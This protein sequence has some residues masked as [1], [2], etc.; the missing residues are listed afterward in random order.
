MKHHFRIVSTVTILIGLIYGCTTSLQTDSGQGGGASETIALTI[1]GDSITGSVRLY[2]DN[3]DSALSNVSI[4]LYEDD[5][6]TY[7]NNLALNFIDSTTTNN[8]GAFTFSNL[9]PGGYN[10]LAKNKV[11]IKDAFLSEIVING[12]TISLIDTLRKT[13]DLSG[14]VWL[15]R[16]NSNSTFD[17]IVAPFYDVYI[18]GSPYANI[19]NANGVFTLLNLAVGTFPVMSMRAR[20]VLDTS[21]WNGSL[22]NAIIIIN[23]AYKNDVTIK[24]ELSLKAVN[25]FTRH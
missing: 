5:Y 10:I 22:E 1:S 13:G 7:V 20:A 18:P 2:F 6:L 21:S 11:S 15:I 4:Y 9:V 24:S 23:S 14:T 19:T 16:E 3:K 12:N 8:Q 25:I 17:T